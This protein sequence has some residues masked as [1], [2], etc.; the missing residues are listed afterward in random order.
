MIYVLR[1]SAFELYLCSQVG[2]PRT[3]LY[4]ERA[5]YPGVV[6]PLITKK[7]LFNWKRRIECFLAEGREAE[8]ERK[9]GQLTMEN[10]FL[11]KVRSF[12]EQQAAVNGGAPS[13]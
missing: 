6:N 2:I 4:F 3:Y 9:I 8:L 13:I 10:D 12:E 7:K 5:I 1:V 11:K